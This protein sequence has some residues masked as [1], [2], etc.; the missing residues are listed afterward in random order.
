MGYGSSIFEEQT[1]HTRKQQKI[2]SIK[3]KDE[4]PNEFRNYKNNLIK[5][6]VQGAELKVLEGL[7]EFID[8]FE[9]IILEVSIHQYN[10]DA[11]LFDQVLNFMIKKNFKLYDIFDLLCSDDICRTNIGEKNIYRDDDH[12]SSEGALYIKD[13][14]K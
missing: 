3:L 6:D 13:H 4:I 14:F 2:K 7:D 9:V 8:N 10:K 5:I 12:F 11:P 1:S